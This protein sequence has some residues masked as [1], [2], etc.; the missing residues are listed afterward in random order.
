MLKRQ[1][2]FVVVSESCMVGNIKKKKI[3]PSEEVNITSN[4]SLVSITLTFEVS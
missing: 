3:N 4:C 1:L 2:V